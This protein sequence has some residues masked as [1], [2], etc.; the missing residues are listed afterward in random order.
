MT[1]TRTKAGEEA[2]VYELCVQCSAPVDTDQRYCVACGARN[3]RSRDPVARYLALATSRARP[4]ARA[5]GTR[6]AAATSKRR[7]A[8][9]G[10]VAVIAVIPVAV[11]VG[12]LVGHS[13]SSNDSK[14]IAALRAQKPPVVHVTEGGT[15]ASLRQATAHAAT[16]ASTFSLASGYAVELGTIPASGASQRAVTAAEQGAR[17]KGATAVG[18]IAAGDFTVTPKPAAGSY[19]LYSGQYRTHA[20]AATALAKL[21]R[22]FPGALVIVVRSRAAVSPSASQVTPT[23]TKQSLATGASEVKRMSHITGKGYVQA[24]NSLPGMVSVP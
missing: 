16:V 5:G 17:A 12:V 19:V 8:G 1:E 22:R 23:A 11:A 3:Q 13:G 4:P 18:V 24:Q 2:K 6:A 20:A 14:L 7:G 10:A 9:L 15:G 21:G